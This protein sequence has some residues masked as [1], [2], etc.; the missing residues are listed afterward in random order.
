VSAATK[1]EMIATSILGA[2]ESI[3]LI[4]ASEFAPDFFV[5]HA[6]ILRLVDKRIPRR[7]LIFDP[8]LPHAHGPALA[9]LE[10]LSPLPLEEGW[11]LQ[12][13]ARA[14]SM[15]C[16]IVDNDRAYLSEFDGSITR[17]LKEPIEVSDVPHV[18]ALTA[19]FNMVWFAKHSDDLLFE[20]LI[21]S[22]VPETEANV[23][24]T[25]NEYWNRL[26][27]QL[28][29]NPENLHSMNPRAFEELVAELLFGEGFEVTLTPKTR[30]GGRDVIA[31]EHT[32]AGQHL[33]LVECKRHA[34]DRPV[35]VDIVRA[36]YGVVEQEKATGGLLVTTSHFS[37]HAW[38][39]RDRVSYRMALRD[40]DA[41][42][43]WLARYISKI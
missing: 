1:L 26:I 24:A 40:Y 7:C 22:S 33:Y 4:I 38:K 31:I 37:S 20:D 2:S 12:V 42:V 8:A 6:G 21:A 35:S 15:S 18:H 11:R 19:H 43:A 14:S 17:K 3:D 9:H 16:L 27:S 32:A 30:D 41:L 34:S 23:I 36:L 10:H 5:T 13:T 29:K 25:A 39:F 28:S